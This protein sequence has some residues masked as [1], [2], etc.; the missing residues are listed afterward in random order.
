MANVLQ[1][2]EIFHSIQGES[3]HAGLPCVFVR[4]TGCNLRCRWCDTEYAFDE[5]RPMSVEAVIGEVERFDC[6][7]VEITGGEPLLQPEVVPLMEHLVER[8]YRVLLETAGSLPIESVPAGVL[9]IMDVKCPASGEVAANRWQNL[10]HLRPSDEVKFVVRD[11]DD[12]EWAVRQVRE[13]GIAGRCTV[14]FSP[15]HDVL[16]PGELSR[17]VLEDGVPVRVQ[18]QLH[19]VLWPGV[20]RGV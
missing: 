8:G 15:V 5:G 1:V 13:R 10:D 3:T 11:R 17:W 20:L 16:D 2:N 4:L 14:L 19:K 12:Y 9:R 6:R 18:I 7:L